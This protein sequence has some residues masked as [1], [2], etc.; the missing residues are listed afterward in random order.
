[1]S[2]LVRD[3]DRITLY[4]YRL[5]EDRPEKST[6]VKLVKLG[7]AKKYYEERVPKSYIVLDPFADSVLSRNDFSKDIIVIDRSW[8]RLVEEKALLKPRGGT[9]KRLPMLK[10][11]NPTNY[12]KLFVLSSAEALASALYILGCKERAEK[13]LGIFKWG[14]EFFRLN[15]ELLDKYFQ[16][17][18][19]QEITQIEKSLLEKIYGIS[20]NQNHK[21]KQ[22]SFGVL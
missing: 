15:G 10:A 18:S 17:N 6:A 16:A 4:V 11:A 20:E 2:E 8:K 13:I 14:K 19:E 7:L 21:R 22:D 1:M 3:C 12:S 5:P 9:R